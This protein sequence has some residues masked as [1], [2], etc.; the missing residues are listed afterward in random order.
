MKPSKGKEEKNAI[1]SGLT[2]LRAVVGDDIEM[3]FPVIVPKTERE[4]YF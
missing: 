2:T 3:D 4:G 1:Y